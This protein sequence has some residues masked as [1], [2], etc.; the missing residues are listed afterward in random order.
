MHVGIASLGSTGLHWF[1]RESDLSLGIPRWKCCG[2][3]VFPPLGLQ[4]MSCFGLSSAGAQVIANR[5]LQ[6]S[7]RSC[8]DGTVWYCD[9]S[10]VWPTDLLLAKGWSFYYLGLSSFSCPWER[11]GLFFFVV[12][13]FWGW[14]GG[15]T[16]GAWHLCWFDLGSNWWLW[17]QWK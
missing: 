14:A 10:S 9:F 4:E 17:A 15:L 13:F 6:R 16:Q 7:K 5:A 1:G 2:W 3:Q 12:V 8:H 11:K